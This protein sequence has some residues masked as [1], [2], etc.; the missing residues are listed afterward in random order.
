MFYA[1]VAASCV[2]PPGGKNPTMEQVCREINAG[3][4]LYTMFSECLLQ[5]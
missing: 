1:L 3:S 2:S 5:T 4:D